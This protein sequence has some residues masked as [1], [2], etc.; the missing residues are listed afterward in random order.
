MRWHGTVG[1]IGQ[2]LSPAAVLV[3]FF[4][5]TFPLWSNA[6]LAAPDAASY[7]AVPRTVF[8]GGN[9]DFTDDY[10]ALEFSPHHFYLTDAGRLSNDW[11]IG[12][13]ILWLPAYGAAHIAAHTATAAGITGHQFS[14]DDPPRRAGLPRPLTRGAYEPNLAPT[15][16]SGIYRLAVTLW[17][18]GF[19]LAA[20]LLAWKLAAPYAGRWHALAAAII[21]LL[22]TPVGFYTYA[23]AMMSHV[24]SLL[25]VGVLLYAWHRTR[26]ERTPAQWALLG[27]LAGAVA[28]V[29]PQDAVFL[30]VFLVEL[31]FE[32]PRG[33]EAWKR[34]ARGVAIAA[35]SAL[36]AFS[37]QMITWWCL[38]GNPLQFPKIE[39]MHWFRPRIADVL[40][41]EYHGLLSWSPVLVLVPLGA[42]VLWKRDRVLAAGFG[43][44][45]LLQV[46]LNAANE[47][48]WA[49]GS[50]GNR[51]F[52]NCGVP[53][54]V[55]LASLLAGVRPAIV[56]TVALAAAGW[57][58]LL[59]ATER[60][61]NLSLA[62]YTPWDGDFL[63]TVLSTANPLA[64]F[65]A[66]MG[67][68]AGFGWT[69]RILIMAAGLAGAVAVQKGLHRRFLHSSQPPGTSSPPGHEN[70][71]RNNLRASGSPWF[72]AKYS[73]PRA[74][75]ALFVVYFAAA[76]P[77]LFLVLA[78]RTPP[79]DTERL[80]FDPYRTPRSLFD[81]Y[82]EYGYF[83]LAKGRPE[84]ARTAYERAAELRPDQPF[85]HRYL[86]AIA[87]EFEGD[88]EAALRHSGRALDLAPA[89]EPALMIKIAAIEQ[90]M[91]EQPHRRAALQERWEQRVRAAEELL[92]RQGR[93]S[94]Q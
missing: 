40:A 76:M 63:A 90:L 88:A 31:V 27:F 24:N 71:E 68:F 83:N 25:T 1:T 94:I 75:I 22:G 26:G 67:D 50:F 18:A 3:A 37:P 10:E 66:M 58:L 47:I 65:P 11:P 91:R 70:I 60:A 74:G 48:W 33:R 78:L 34:W 6:Y 86:A 5:V 41:S 57:N 32:P 64:F 36:L 7:F 52:V 2:W 55:L 21:V 42:A 14:P 23:F 79:A 4:A 93:P 80:P 51:R 81:G 17:S 49:G 12:S 69:P 77:L 54:A 84:R 43:A 15:G 35:G 73:P 8:F 9:L 20:L 30:C 46:Y 87:L 28:M 92:E 45:V 53:F 38:Y 59:W 85:P 89:Y 61:G 39:E 62:H 72:I 13:G 19:S 56:Y 29:R 16:Q 44:G 82:Y